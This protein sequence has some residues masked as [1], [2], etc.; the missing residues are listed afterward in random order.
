ME[1][2]AA[3]AALPAVSRDWIQAKAIFST[4]PSEAAAFGILPD[5]GE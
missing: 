3:R 5:C 2:G 1:G 4:L